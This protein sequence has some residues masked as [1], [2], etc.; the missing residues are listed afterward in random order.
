MNLEFFIAKRIHFQHKKKNISRPAVRIATIGMTLGLAVMLIALAVVLGFKHQ[1]R[2]K[3]IGFGGHI[4]ITNFDSNNSYETTPINP[5]EGF[6]DSLKMIDGVKHVQFFA[7]KPGII[8]TQN[9]FQGVIFKAVDENFDWSF[10]RKNIKEGEVLNISADSL[11]NNILISKHLANLLDLKLGDSFF[12]YF[13]QN[14]ARARKF[15]ISGIYSTDF[16]DFDKLFILCDLRHVQNLNGWNENQYSGIEILVSNFNKL[17]EVDNRVFHFVFEKNTNER[18][19]FVQNIKSINS[20]IFSW[21]NLLDLNVW[22]IFGLMLAVA[23]FNLISG[24][25]ILILERTQMI[26]ILKSIGAT[27]WSVRKIFIYHSLFLI[28][29]GMFWGNLIGLGLCALQYFTGFMTMPDPESYYLTVVPIE[30][31]WLYIILL[32]IGT[33]LISLLMMFIPSYLITKIH[34]AKIIKYE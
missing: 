30:F 4:Q 16:I 14:Q 2:E 8:K 13:I 9:D 33:L 31:N 18:S 29:R 32:N 34:P 24:L 15:T 6:I 23:G 7:T 10:F 19:Y 3:T 22:I 25:L 11:T 21:L 17:E 28:R 27:N 5:T 26:G 20:Q 1:I 12:A